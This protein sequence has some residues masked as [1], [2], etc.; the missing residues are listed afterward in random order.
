MIQ[1]A[2][3]GQGVMWL[4]PLLTVLLL[5]LNP[6]FAA[7][8][9]PL[10][11][12][13]IYQPTTS[14]YYDLNPIAVQP[15]V[16]HEKAHKDDRVESWHAR[17]YDMGMNFTLNFCA[18]VIETIED[19]VGIKGSLLKN[20][21]AFYEWKGKTYSIG[22]TSTEL[23]FRGR[24]LSLNYTNGSPCDSP[25]T[26]ERRKLKHDDDEDDEDDD[27][28]GKK[29]NKEVDDDDDDDEKNSHRGKPSKEE[30]DDVRRKSTLISLACD[31]NLP[32]GKAHVSFIGSSPDQCTYF[33]RAKTMAACGGVKEPPTGLG[34]GGVFGVI[35]IIFLAV[36]LLGGIAYQ[37]TVMH[38]RG[39]R[40]LPNYTVWAPIGSLL[41]DIFIILTSSC[42]RL[43]P[44][45]HGY[46]QL[47]GNGRG[48][49]SRADDENRLIDQLDEESSPQKASMC[50]F[51]VDTK[52]APLE[53][54]GAAPTLM[55][56]EEHYK[57]TLAGQMEGPNN[58]LDGH[59]PTS[60]SIAQS[61]NVN[62]KLE[63]NKLVDQDA[64][65]SSGKRRVSVPVKAKVKM[66]P[67]C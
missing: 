64:T 59:N 4:T 17:G 37:R 26:H 62:E 34:A 53:P 14:A 65:S 21:S 7:D 20:I 28:K 11:P 10:A 22:Q 49:G 27:K 50:F 2:I 66:S 57:A 44:R 42:A 52:H 40:Q 6:C 23:V 61:L 54:P 60:K 39:W 48:R 51:K 12:C 15:L 3:T 35:L 38:Q 67:T 32:S 56:L 43:L 18:P 13:T 36:Y 9:K 1:E 5:H 47:P 55:T 45:R 16:D 58:A 19:A 31:Q 24:E 63:P 29:K 41:R 30:E 25:K 33:F 8:A 46:N